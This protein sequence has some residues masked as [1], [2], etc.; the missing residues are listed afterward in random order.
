VAIALRHRNCEMRHVVPFQGEDVSFLAW[1]SSLGLNLRSGF[2]CSHGTDP[3][4]I[5]GQAIHAGTM[6][7]SCGMPQ[8]DPVSV[9]TEHCLVQ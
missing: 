5:R 2:S 4:A 1:S 9:G 7:W 8:T 3:E 6:L